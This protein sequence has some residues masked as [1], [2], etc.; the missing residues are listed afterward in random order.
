MGAPG[1]P[2]AG[3]PPTPGAYLGGQMPGQ[4]PVMP[5]QMP[6]ML[7][8]PVAFTKPRRS[9]GG[10]LIMLIIL[11]GTL[12]G[13]GAAIWGVMKANDAVN[14][15]TDLTD[16]HLSS[17]DRAKL[18]LPGNVQYLWDAGAPAAIATAFDNGIDG[19]PTNFTQISLYSDYAF[20][21]AQNTTLPD[22]FDQ[23]GWR[24]GSL[25]SGAPQPNDADA[26]TLTFT[27]ADMNWNALAAVAADAVNVSK[28]EEGTISHIIVD[29]DDFSDSHPLIARIYV[30]GPRSSAYIEVGA[31]GTVIAVR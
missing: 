19:Q 3:G 24:T 16:K 5:G 11:A 12:G 26:A 14:H 17:N 4:M 23:Y 25:S 20:A 28:V 9:V 31:D 18:S 29:R 8:G 22:H 21:T 27:V 7:G 1:M 2:Y 10:I 15:A 30:S 13:I 6:G